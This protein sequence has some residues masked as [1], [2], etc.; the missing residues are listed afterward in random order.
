MVEDNNDVIGCSAF[1][2]E[3]KGTEAFVD[4]LS[5]SSTRGVA[6]IC[7]YQRVA[8]D[9]VCTNVSCVLGDVLS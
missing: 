6:V 1:K 4:Y 7:V 5:P 8:F 3:K 2:S 9:Y